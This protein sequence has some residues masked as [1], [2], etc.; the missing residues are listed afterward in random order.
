[1]TRR[2]A[3]D[4]RQID[5]FEVAMP[6]S[7]PAA[8]AGIEAWVSAQL[9]EL[10]KRDPRSRD[11][12]A[13][14]MAADM[15]APVSVRMLEKCASTRSPEHNISLARAIVLMAVTADRPMIEMIVN[16]LGGSV[17]WGEEIN[18]A[19]LGHLHAQRTKIDSEIKRL[20]RG[21]AQPIERNSGQ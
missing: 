2:H 5:L 12:I 16:R 20:S 17:L 8:H 21:G 3:F 18:A 10:L 7:G 14:A 19:Y 11:E 6:L 13:G 1:M 4:P 15:V 9:G